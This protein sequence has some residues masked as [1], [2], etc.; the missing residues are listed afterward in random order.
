MK[1]NAGFRDP[2]RN[3]LIENKNLDILS[4]GQF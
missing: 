1:I 3:M 4:R 2:I